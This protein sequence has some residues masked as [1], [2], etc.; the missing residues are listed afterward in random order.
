MPAPDLDRTIRALADPHRRALL[1]TLRARD[2][3]A[4]RDLEGVLPELGRHAVLKHLRA[5]E[6]A[7]LVIT[8][9][10]GRSRFVHLNP[11]PIVDLA[12]RWLD[13]YSAFAGLALARL[14]DHLEPGRTRQGEPMS[15][16]RTLVAT[17]VIEATAEKVWQAIVD[18]EQSRR[19][20]FGGVV[21]SDWQVGGPI[22][23][24]DA[25]GSSL[26]AGEITAIEP[27]VR[28]AH[29]FSATWSPETAADPVSTYEWTLESM[30][31]NLTRVTITHSDVPVGSATEQQVDGGNSLVISALKTYVETGRTMAG[32]G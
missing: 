22:E 20:F 14:R 1:D 12:R 30:G 24:V 2:G 8:R 6:A 31:E 7:E 21:R 29:T 10:V 5:L 25:E 23:W 13:D 17:A 9:K 19:W 16:T 26:I 15:T 3:Q 28:L 4:V 27:G 18:P 32:M 11:T